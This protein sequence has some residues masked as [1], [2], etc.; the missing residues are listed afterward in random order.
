MLLHTTLIA[1]A[2]LAK[3][4]LGA[5]VDDAVDTLEPFDLAQVEGLQIHP[6]PG[7]PSLEDLGL[8]VAQLF[9]NS[10]SARRMLKR[11]RLTATADASPFAPAHV[12]KRATVCRE[13]STAKKVRAWAAL[14]C[15]LYL[16]S[17]GNTACSATTGCVQMCWAEYEGDSAIISGHSYTNGLSTSYC[18]HVARTV[19]QIIRDCTTQHG[20]GERNFLND[21]GSE[22]AWGNGNLGISVHSIPF[23]WI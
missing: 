22:R 15:Q 21:G 10:L 19:E 18:R 1:L 20:P 13:F 11:E 17:L 7:L 6:G 5:P 4:S 14:G 2:A 9:N 12:D 3:L 16:E 8:T 23:C